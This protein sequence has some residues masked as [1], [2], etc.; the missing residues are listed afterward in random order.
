[1]KFSTNQL[2]IAAYWLVAGK[3]GRVDGDEV[4]EG[5]NALEY[6]KILEQNEDDWEMIK[7]LYVTGNLHWDEIIGYISELPLLT[8]YYMNKMIV[9][10]V[11][12]TKGKDN[13]DVDSWP[14]LEQFCKDVGIVIKAYN[15]WAKSKIK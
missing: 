4:N 6:I 13:R 7:G 15:I 1:M 8:R 14:A 5:W 11:K 9:H 3:D 10:G 12:R 2:A